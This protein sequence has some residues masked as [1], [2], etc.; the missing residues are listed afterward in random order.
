VQQGLHGAQE[1]AL[2]RVVKKPRI[3]LTSASHITDI[4]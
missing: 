1:K 4:T 2:G 3:K